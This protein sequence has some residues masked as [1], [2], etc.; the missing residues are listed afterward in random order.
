MTKIKKKIFEKN[1]L[2]APVDSPLS[3]A[4]SEDLNSE[5]SQL[6]T[7]LPAPSRVASVSED[8]DVK[9]ET[10]KKNLSMY[11]VGDQFDDQGI[12]GRVFFVSRNL[13]KIEVPGQGLKLIRF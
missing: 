11:N 1:A 12:K 4:L 10:L 6:E 5:F 13:I 7:E 8:I 2:E 9:K 3:D